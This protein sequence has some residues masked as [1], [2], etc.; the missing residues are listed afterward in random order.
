RTLRARS[1]R[2]TAVGVLATTLT[3]AIGALSAAAT[4]GA[5]PGIAGS[6]DFSSRL[7]PI[8]GFGFSAAF[9]RAALIHNMPLDQQQQIVDLLLSPRDGAGL[10]ILR[11]SIGSAPDGVGDNRSIEPVDPGSPSTP[12]VYQWDVNDSGQLWL[13]EQARAFGVKR[14]Y[15]DA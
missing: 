6:A 14:F 11:M 10:S 12:P 7:Q 2:W 4:D 8:D 13:A 5:P 3:L 9:G 15:A 1:K